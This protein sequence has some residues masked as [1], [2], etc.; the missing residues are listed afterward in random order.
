MLN[1]MFICMGYKTVIV[2]LTKP[3]VWQPSGTEIQHL[4]LGLL[5]MKHTRN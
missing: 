4:A 3:L 1:H 5:N 2:T